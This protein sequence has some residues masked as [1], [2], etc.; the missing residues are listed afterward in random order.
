MDIESIKFFLR[1]RRDA[2]P[3]I[4]IWDIKSAKICLAAE[5]ALRSD[6][7]AHHLLNSLSKNIII[8][9]E[10]WIE[11][12]LGL[13]GRPCGRRFRGEAGASEQINADFLQSRFFI[14]NLG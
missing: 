12:E 5:A 2:H 13:A 8:F 9:F 14:P 11:A 4:R 3:G 7:R 1:L 10:F 6:L